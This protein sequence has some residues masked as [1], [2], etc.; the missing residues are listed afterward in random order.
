MRG[1]SDAT[2]KRRLFRFSLRT[3]FVVVTLAGLFLGWRAYCLDWIR[4]RHDWID[5]PTSV[6]MHCNGGHSPPWYLRLFGEKQGLE[7]ISM[8]FVPW[9]EPEP[10]LTAEQRVQYDRI[11]RLFPEAVI[12]TSPLDGRRPKNLRVIQ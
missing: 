2:P 3:L 8:R 12:S 5:H 6:Y 7:V 4:Q 10:E 9:T 11:Q 1:M